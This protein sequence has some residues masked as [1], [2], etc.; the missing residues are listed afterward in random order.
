M[1]RSM[2]LRALLFVFFGV[3]F[4]FKNYVIVIGQTSVQP[5]ATQGSSASEDNA[6][7]I[8][9]VNTLFAEMAAANPAGIIAVHTPESQLVA[10]FKQKD[11][12]SVMKTF[13]GDAFSKM[14]ADKTKV[15][16]ERMYAPESKIFGDLAMV[17]GRYVFFA[18]GK[19]SHCGVNSFHLVRTDAGW[20]IGGGSS[21]IDP[22]GCTDT[23]KAMKLAT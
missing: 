2:K 6:L 5:A 17:W 12:K 1:P 7:A 21:T 23:E 13:N 14:F 3:I 20:K 8:A 15:M 19:L 18:N 22:G 16:N 4:V 9:T 11:G 10:L